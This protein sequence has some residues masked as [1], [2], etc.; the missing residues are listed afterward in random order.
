MNFPVMRERLS[1]QEGRSQR[2]VHAVQND[3]GNPHRES[4]GQGWE[5]AAPQGLPWYWG[6][7]PFVKTSGREGSPGRPELGGALRVHRSLVSPFSTWRLS[8]EGPP[9]PE[10]PALPGVT[11]PC[12]PRL[13]EAAW[14]DRPASPPLTFMASPDPLQRPGDKGQLPDPAA[15]WMRSLSRGFWWLLGHAGQLARPG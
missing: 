12:S 11:Q 4:G 10:R 6:M 5:E 14:P 13:Q 7:A 8:F 1:H 2:R 15:H 3:Q 9:Q